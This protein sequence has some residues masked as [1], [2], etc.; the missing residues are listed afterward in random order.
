MGRKKNRGN[1]NQRQQRQQSASNAAKAGNTQ[2]GTPEKTVE[3]VKPITLDDVKASTSQAE[4]DAK[5]EQLLQQLL[6]EISAWEDS[7]KAA[8][9][10]AQEAQ[11]ALDQLEQKKKE[12]SEQKDELQKK[13]DAIQKEY[14]EAEQTVNRAKDNAETIK[15][16]ADTYSK[17]TRAAADTYAEDVK[18]AADEERLKKLK[19][20]ADEAKAAWQTQIDDLSNQ[21]QEIAEREAALHE[22]QRQLAKEKRFVED[23]KEALDELKEDLQARKS[24]Y[25]AANPTKIAKLETELADERSKYTALLE[26]YHELQKRL[27]ALQVLMDTVKTEIEDP[28]NGI[29]IA[30]MNEIISALQELRDKYASLASVYERYP[31]DAAIS[32]LEEKAHKTDEL[33]RANEALELERNRYREEVIAARNATKELEIVKQEVEATTALNEHLLQELESHKTALESRTGDTCPSLSKVDTETEA[34]D[35][36][37]D[38]M[39]RMQRPE[40]SNLGDIVTHVKNFAG[41]R[42]IEEQLYYTDNDIRA[43]LAGMAVSRLIILQGMSGTGK[44][45]LP[46]IFSQAISGFN[47]LIPVESSWRDRN[48]LL[49]YYNDFNKKFNAKSFTIELYRSSKERCQV[50]P[51]F[52]VLDEMNLARIEYYFSDFLAILQEPDHDKWLIELVSSDMRTLPMELPDSV[53]AKMQREDPAIYAIWEKIERSRQGDLKAETSDEDKE[54]LTAYL[55]KM[56][57]LTGAK[58][59]IDGRKIKVTDNI[60]FIGTANRDESTFEISD[61][62]YDRAQVVSLNRKGVSEGN[63][64]PVNTKY[65][66]VDKLLALFQEAINNNQYKKEVEERLEALDSV[67]MEKFDLSFG[68]R[69]VTQTINFVGVYTAAKGSI[70]DALDYQISTKIL[71]KVITSDDEEALLELL[72]AVKDYPETTRL[73]EKRLRELR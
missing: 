11:N 60:W 54:L 65:I 43:F 20:A 47:R 66:S 21:I 29:R 12:L 13:V 51:T 4:F 52:I 55:S 26:R 31:D 5:K 3:E 22:A 24:R 27:E 50:I 69:I 59:L 45:S 32:E 8:E 7:K 17:E 64:T 48:E 58:D 42:Q 2:N 40:L 14:S 68:N 71:R 38:V 1:N 23:E 49:G 56:G 16:D 25:D 46:R 39:K 15:G 28:E 62:V 30:S 9:T 67:L 70:N 19:E 37:A 36:K 72:E 57:Q 63:Y 44:S 61:K 53:K 10:A 35:F 18:K 34:D 73:L 33:E 41:S 6:S